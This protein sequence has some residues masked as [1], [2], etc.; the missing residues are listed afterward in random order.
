MECSIGIFVR[1]VC[2][3][4]AYSTSSELKTIS[5][6]SDEKKKLLV[7]RSGCENIKNICTYHEKKYLDK[8]FHI[9]GKRCCDPYQLHKKT[10][11]QSLREITPTTAANCTQ[12]IL[13]PGKALCS[14]CLQ[15]VQTTSHISG[16]DTEQPHDLF[17]PECVL[18]ESVNTAC[19]ALGVSPVKIQKLSKCAR[20]PV[21][22]KKVSKIAAVVSDKLQKSFNLETS[23]QDEEDTNCN[24]L[25]NLGSEYESLIEELRKKFRTAETTKEKVG[26]L[27]LLPKSWSMKK[28]QTE[29]NASQYL[30]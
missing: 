7:L 16:D 28:I 8:Y 22:K 21:L 26:I 18:V 30:V 10:V 2:H 9:H 15:K 4:L 6:V 13:I 11:K 29:F 1:E 12:V 24:D 14:K 17:E 20:P 3:N 25:Q 27:S 19:S 23:L 5:D